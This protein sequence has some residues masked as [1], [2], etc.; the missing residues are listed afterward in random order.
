[1]LRVTDPRSGD[2]LSTA[3]E[4]LGEL[5][6]LGGDETFASKIMNNMKSNKKELSPK[7]PRSERFALQR[8]RREELLGA[9]K[10]RFEKNLG[11]HPGLVW[12]KVLARLEA[13][14]K[15]FVENGA[16]VYAKA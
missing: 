5:L 1:M 3:R 2:S 7:Q 12:A 4:A 13:K 15:E 6:Y 9:L 10:A 16:E 11:R 14:S 8:G